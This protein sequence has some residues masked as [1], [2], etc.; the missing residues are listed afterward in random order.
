[1]SSEALLEYVIEKAGLDPQKYWGIY[2]VICE[3]EIGKPDLSN[4]RDEH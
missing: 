4:V 2:E 1:M 3:Q